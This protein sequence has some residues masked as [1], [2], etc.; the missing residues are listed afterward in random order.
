MSRVHILMRHMGNVVYWNADE[1]DNTDRLHNSEIPSI[2]TNHCHHL[3]NDC[4]DRVGCKKTYNDILCRD[5]KNNESKAKTNHYT[6]L[7]V[8][9]YDLIEF[10]PWPHVFRRQ[11]KLKW[12]STFF[13]YIISHLFYF[14]SK[15]FSCCIIQWKESVILKCYLC[16]YQFAINKACF[17]ICFTLIIFCFEIISGHPIIK[18]FFRHWESNIVCLLY[19]CLESYIRAQYTPEQTCLRYFLTNG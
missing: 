5:N 9:Y 12:W 19:P 17:P 7:S 10:D 4:G 18:L 14:I 11:E 15:C 16:K 8:C 3:A 2:E 1:D 6:L 13:I